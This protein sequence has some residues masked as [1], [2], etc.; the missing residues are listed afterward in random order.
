MEEVLPLRRLVTERNG[1][2][3]IPLVAHLA[4][5]HAYPTRHFFGLL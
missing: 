4:V 1:Q 2:N 3:S 5:D